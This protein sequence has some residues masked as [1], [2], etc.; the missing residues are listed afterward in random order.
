M[1]ITTVKIWGETYSLRANWAE[2]SCPI[3]RQTEDGW[4]STGMQVADYR[5]SAEAAMRAELEAALVAGGD[6]PDE[7][8]NRDVIDTALAEIP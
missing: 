8:E 7:P 5:H 3:E 4:E 2:A 1:G 6:D